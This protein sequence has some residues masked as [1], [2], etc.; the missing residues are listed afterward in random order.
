[1]RKLR[2]DADM[3][4]ED[5]QELTGLAIS[6]TSKVENDLQGPT[7][8]TLEKYAKALK[9]SDVSSLEVAA[10]SR[11]LQGHTRPSSSVQGAIF[12]IDRTTLTELLDISTRIRRVVD[13]IESG[14]NR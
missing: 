2:V 7:R 14:G 13:R 9:F 5:L 1:L 3:T 11:A 10:R 8:K 4:L 12:Q 6:T